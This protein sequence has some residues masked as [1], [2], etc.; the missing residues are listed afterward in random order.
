MTAMLGI[1]ERM[2]SMGDLS[3]EPSMEEILSSIKRIIAEEGEAPGRNRRTPRASAA[4]QAQ[5]AQLATPKFSPADEVLE[6]RDPI[7][8]THDDEPTALDVAR[9][10]QAMAAPAVAEPL[11]EAPT[12]A[13]PPWA[14]EEPMPADSSARAAEA[15]PAEA[16]IVSPRTADASRGSL[17]QLS[18]LLVKPEPGGDGTLEGLVREMLRPMLRDWLDSNLP[19]LVESMVAREIARITAARD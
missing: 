10:I 8:A 12:A 14:A 19:P 15:K 18:R 16:P 4:S 1:A 17:D 13:S 11:A 5:H 2:G 3:A 7:P 6:L 9:R